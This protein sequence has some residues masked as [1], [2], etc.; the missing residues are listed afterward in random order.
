MLLLQLVRAMRSFIVF[1]TLVAVVNCASAPSGATWTV[2]DGHHGTCIRLQSKITLNVTYNVIPKNGEE[3]VTNTTL[4]T[5]DDHAT[6]DNDK[7][8]CGTNVA[9]GGS[10]VYS[11]LLT[12]D[13]SHTYPGWSLTL[14]FTQDHKFHATTSEFVLYRVDITGNYTA[15]EALFPN[16]KDQ[17]YEYT[18]KIDLDDDDEAT[19]LSDVI[20]TNVKYSY[21][22]NSKQTFV[23][24][25]GLRAWISFTQFHVQA[26]SASGTSKFLKRETCPQDQADHD[27]VPV[28]VGAV[29]AALVT[30]TLVIYL[31]YRARQPP[32][33]LYLTNAHSHFED[34]GN[35]T[36]H[37]ENEGF[38][39]DSHSA[40]NEGIKAAGMGCPTAGTNQP[41]CKALVLTVVS[42][43]SRQIHCD[44]GVTR[45]SKDSRTIGDNRGQGGA[46]SI[47]TVRSDP[48]ICLLKRLATA[49][50][51]EPL[52]QVDSVSAPR[53]K[54][55][56]K[57]D[58]LR[59][60]TLYP[61]P[62]L[63]TLA[64]WC[65][66]A[67]SLVLAWDRKRLQFIVATR[68]S[69]NR[70]VKAISNQT[71][72]YLNFNKRK[73]QQNAAVEQKRDPFDFHSEMTAN[74]RASRLCHRPFNMRLSRGQA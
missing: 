2:D 49:S 20:Y 41:A 17:I 51:G 69:N 8:S 55:V 4:L 63:F 38:T 14:Y 59:K 61:A 57:A 53:K 70:M 72:F 35:P 15:N 40:G 23:L 45:T 50:S 22:C 27:L 54:G 33:V 19:E 71:I 65:R 48:C 47:C 32:S 13:L 64:T 12:L 21:Y 60:L 30:A 18:N 56:F 1:A 46:G 44:V 74:D 37:H 7:S 28:I 66:K 42:F 24:N 58:V 62:N 52:F 39:E 6:V 11:Q 9:L 73:K 43:T 68:S 29:L 5:V 16:H 34:F 3:H 26:F 36:K 10:D 25:R 31:V 67:N